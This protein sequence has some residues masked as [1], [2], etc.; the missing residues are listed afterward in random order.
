MNIWRGKDTVEDKEEKT[1][2]PVIIV[3]TQRIFPALPFPMLISKTF[4]PKQTPHVKPILR[5][6]KGSSRTGIR[7]TA[8]FMLCFPKVFQQ[9]I[10]GIVVSYP[11]VLCVV[12]QRSS[13]ECFVTA[14]RCNA[15]VAG[16]Y[17]YFPPLLI[18]R[19]SG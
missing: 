6:E 5:E 8:K 9:I 17:P 16:E 18:K 12:K 14:K 7:E 10:T 1:T 2:F 3:E 4:M 13:L 15:I 19:L 11:A